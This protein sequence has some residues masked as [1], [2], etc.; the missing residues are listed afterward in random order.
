M[1]WL[2]HQRATT[3]VLIYFS[4]ARN[5]VV[6]TINVLILKFMLGSQ[7]FV[8]SSDLNMT[9]L[10]LRFDGKCIELCRSSTR[11]C[12]VHGSFQTNSSLQLLSPG[13][14]FDLARN[15]TKNGQLWILRKSLRY[16]QPWLL[17]RI[18]TWGRVAGCELTVYDGTNLL[19]WILMNYRYVL[20]LLLPDLKY[21][22][23]KKIQVNR[24][25]KQE[26]G[27]LCSVKCVHPN[28]LR[29][30][31]LKRMTERTKIKKFLKQRCKIWR[32]S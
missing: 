5:L 1:A 20:E 27:K 31:N 22:Y 16:R 26:T 30:I 14:N 29:F 12:V 25:S 8:Y 19:Q 6:C 10:K 9:V 15:T 28:L 18:V 24:N 7:K 4:V 21:N 13:I 17:Y 3:P 23:D 2:S 11:L 32:N